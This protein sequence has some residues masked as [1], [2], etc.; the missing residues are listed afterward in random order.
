MKNLEHLRVVLTGG[1][2]GIGK[3]TVSA[4]LQAGA[5]VV[6]TARRESVAQEV[7]D[8]CKSYVDAGKLYFYKADVANKEEVQQLV[9]F[10]DRVMGGCNTLVN[11]AGVFVGGLL[12]ESKE[13]DF[14]S[15]YSVNVKGIYNMCK[16]FLPQM[17]EQKSGT[18]INIAS[19]AGKG[20]EYNMPLY[21]SS[22]AA[23]I[24]LTQSMAID[25]APMGIRI[26]C[27]S[28]SATATP[29]F[30]NGTTPDVMQRFLDAFP[31]HRLGTPQEV[32]NVIL[33]LASDE[34]SFVY[35]QNIAVDGGLSSWVGEP[36]Q[37]KENS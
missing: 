1:S 12:H 14:D 10:V 4:F 36:K 5:Q 9:A 30:L 32:A 8:E 35:G 3:E 24:N 19:V 33:F 37:D 25:Y 21:S 18:I 11:N 6:F 27:I 7:L 17:I 34:S 13:E 16:Y 29:M 31:P 22:K 2:Q 15:I 28:P 26:N 20:G 23:V